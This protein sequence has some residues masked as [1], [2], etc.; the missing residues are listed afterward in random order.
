MQKKL[1]LKTDKETLFGKSG[2]E[3]REDYHGSNTKAFPE[4]KNVNM[5]CQP[6]SAS[7]II[8]KNGATDISPV[9]ASGGTK[10]QIGVPK[11]TI[12]TTAESHYMIN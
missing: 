3:H 6:H 9:L 2:Q 10:N 12:N 7:S 11:L 8:Q 5:L 4:S 1:K